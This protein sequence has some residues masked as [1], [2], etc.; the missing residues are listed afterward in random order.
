MHQTA[1]SRRITPWE[2]GTAVLP[3]KEGQAR[4]SSNDVVE[5]ISIARA[6]VEEHIKPK[7]HAGAK[8]FAGLVASK[9]GIWKRHDTYMEFQ[10][11]LLKQRSKDKGIARVQ[12]MVLAEL[13]SADHHPTMGGCLAAVE[14]IRDHIS[15]DAMTF[16]DS[17]SNLLSNIFAGL[18]SR[19]ATRLHAELP[20]RILRAR[21]IWMLRGCMFG[22]PPNC[23]VCLGPVFCRCVVWPVRACLV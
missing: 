20:R 1:F 22:I 9:A 11:V 12:N 23:S 6:L 3:A 18:G 14:H 17:V 7:H 2:W 8:D 19:T 4:V 10:T 16:V 15:S 13:P 5:E 21:G